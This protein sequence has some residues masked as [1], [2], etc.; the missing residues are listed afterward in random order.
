VS[1][2]LVVGGGISGLTAAWAGADAG[3]DVIVLEAAQHVGG[4]L[5]S[6]EVG[7]VAV[8]VG[9]EALLAVRPEGR[10]LIEQAG[11]VGELITPLTTAAKIRAGGR[12]HGLPARTVMGI[13]TDLE[14]VRASGALSEAGIA[15]VAAEPELPPLPPLTEDIGVGRLVRDRLGDEVADRLVEPLLG[16]VY[17]G[18]ADE[19]SL[20][21]TVRPLAAWL[22]EHG[23][24]L[25][26]AARAVAGAGTRSSSGGP[27]FVSLRGGLG[28]LPTT[29]AASGRFAVRTGVTVRSI[30]RT[31]AGFALETGAVPVAER[32]EADAVVVAVPPAK[33]ARLLREVAPA[34]AADLAAVESASTALVSLAYRGNPGVEGSGLLV[35]A[36]ERLAVK[37]I[38]FSSAK[39][40]I[41]DDHTFLLRASIGRAGESQ[42]L[43]LDDAELVAL[44]RR[45]LRALAGIAAAPMDALVTRWGGGLPQYAVGHLDRIARVR[46]DVGRVP[47]LAIC[48]AAVDGVGVPA[49]IGAARVAIATLAAGTRSHPERGQ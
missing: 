21:A 8:D 17:A 46:A 12:S 29:L 38:T 31:P 27:V 45:E 23:G 43:R 28:V 25:V 30:A 44:A 48:G 11:L 13:P 7:G 5:R 20:R 34:A 41:G 6:R 19:L 35:A 4:K 18:R 33:A 26:E 32:L 1:R 15:A 40:P 3:F 47:G 16:G 24:S 10:E 22:G 42:P 14:A 37:G 49:C 2:L 9:A 36:G 39:W